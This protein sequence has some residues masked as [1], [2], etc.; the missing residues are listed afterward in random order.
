MDLGK[1][2]S[3]INTPEDH[4]LYHNDAV[5]YIY[6]EEYYP[7]CMSDLF[8][9]PSPDVAGTV[10][11]Y[12][13]IGVVVVGLIVLTVVHNRRRYN[14][15]KSFQCLCCCKWISCTSCGSHADDAVDR[16][17]DGDRGPLIIPPPTAPAA[18]VPQGVALSVFHGVRI[19]N[20]QRE[21]VI[22]V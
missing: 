7:I 9:T 17:G 11:W 19:K 4:S 16:S 18:P 5:Y 8:N 3:E 20:T 13:V 21:C 14:E 1:D 2:L 6:I 15:H 10:V 12:S 22:E